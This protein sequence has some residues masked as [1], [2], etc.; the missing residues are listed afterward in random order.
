MKHEATFHKVA[1]G[2]SGVFE[3]LMKLVAFRE[4]VFHGITTQDLCASWRLYD[5]PTVAVE[6]NPEP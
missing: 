3:G 5:L 6:K 4:V 2:L 1:A